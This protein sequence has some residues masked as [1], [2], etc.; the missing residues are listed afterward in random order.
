MLCLVKVTSKNYQVY[1]DS[2]N[3]ECFFMEYELTYRR[4]PATS[5]ES[6]VRCRPLGEGVGDGWR[7]SGMSLHNGIM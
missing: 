5:D 2:L 3:K 1:F 4:V 7:G 6:Q